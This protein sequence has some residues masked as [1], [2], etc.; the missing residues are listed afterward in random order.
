[1]LISSPKRREIFVSLSYSSP[2]I[3][4]IES[5]NA[6]SWEASRRLEYA[7]IMVAMLYGKTW[8]TLETRYLYS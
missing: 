1:M 4:I 7:W 2:V 5:S 6:Y 8:N 3:H